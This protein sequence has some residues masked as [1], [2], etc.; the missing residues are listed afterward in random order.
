MEIFWAI[1]GSIFFLLIMYGIIASK[2]KNRRIRKMTEKMLPKVTDHIQADRHY[3]IFLSHG[4]TLTNVRFIGI[5]T[6]VNDQNPFL[7]FPL[8]QWLIV[9][10]ENGKRA[11]LKPESVRFY[12]DV[13]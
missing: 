13:D 9:E 4:K 7:P 2:I 10:K 6:P 5:S 12:E 1:F 3:N 11:Y 8:N